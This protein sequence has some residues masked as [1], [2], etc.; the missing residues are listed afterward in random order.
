MVIEDAE[1]S[2][3]HAYPFTCGPKRTAAEVCEMVQTAVSQAAKSHHARDLA[4]L[5][6]AAGTYATKEELEAAESK[7]LEELKGL[8]G[9]TFT[10]SVTR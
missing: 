7:R 9:K 6:E 10:G 3:V 8:V 2:N 4:T 5:G 1:G